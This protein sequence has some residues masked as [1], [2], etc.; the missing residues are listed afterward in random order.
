MPILTVN[1]SLHFSM[2]RMSL[3]SFHQMQSN[4]VKYHITVG[5]Q[6][7]ITTAWYNIIDQI[8]N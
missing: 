7:E 4:Q 2:K 6:S 1:N 3:V 8:I 5:N